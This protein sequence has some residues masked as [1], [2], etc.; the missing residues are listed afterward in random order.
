MEAL[1]ALST[2]GDPYARPALCAGAM[3]NS[4]HLYACTPARRL[5]DQ[6]ARATAP[7]GP[8]EARGQSGDDDACLGGADDESS[9]AE[10]FESA[11]AATRAMLRFQVSQDPVF[12]AR[13]A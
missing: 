6:L 10:R 5:R 3:T 1:D 9:G 11:P 2:L 12:P 7:Q 8:A 4:L 13:R